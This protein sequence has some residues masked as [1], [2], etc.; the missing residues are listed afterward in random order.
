MIS[1]SGKSFEGNKRKDVLETVIGEWLEKTFLSKG[2]VRYFLN[3]KEE[4]GMCISRERRILCRK[5]RKKN[6][7]E[8]KALV[9]GTHFVM[10]Q[11]QDQCG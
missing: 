4:P 6:S 8:Y 1:D 5:T 9:M 2:N 11:K 3:E 7:R 10:V